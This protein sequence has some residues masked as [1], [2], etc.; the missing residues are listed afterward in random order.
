MPVLTGEG[1]SILEITLLGSLLDVL[2]C[3]WGEKKIQR[4]G[5]VAVVLYNLCMKKAA[6]TALCE[7]HLHVLLYYRE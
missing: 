6:L 5:F 7:I 2:F 3:M 4:G 1:R